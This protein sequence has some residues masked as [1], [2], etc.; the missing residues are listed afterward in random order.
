MEAMIGLGAASLLIRLGQALY[1]TG[2]IRAKNAAGS[3]LRTLADL[4]F[5]TLAFWAVGAAIFTQTRNPWFS[6]DLS[7]IAFKGTADLFFLL[8]V[9]LVGTG[10]FGGAVAERS[11]FFP[12]CAASILLAGLVI[13]I[14]ANW[15]WH[16]W[17]HRLGFTDVG[18]GAW[19]HL[20]GAVCAA[21]G[22]MLVG[23]RTGKYHRDGS[24][25][26]IPGH[27]VP[28]TGLG[29]LT[30]LVGWAPYL[31]GCAAFNG[32][33]TLMGAAATDTL[34]SAA[35]AGA[36]AILFG[37]YR[38]GKPDVILTLMGFLGGLVAISAGAGRIPAGWAFVVGAFAGL[39]VPMCAV[40]ID[41]FARLDDPIGAIA[42]HGVGGIWGTIAAGLLTYD[43]DR[44]RIE[45]VGI[46]IVGMLAIGLL[47]LVVSVALFAVLRAAGPIRVNEDHEFEGLDLAEHDIG[48]YPDFQ[49]TMIKS[50]HL[51][52]V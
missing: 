31:A 20:S 52:E 41:L 46:Q 30:M 47:S 48:A 23:P 28:M 14:G 26:M 16:G 11:R 29:A 4:C 36:A 42:I 8:A 38:Y 5:A 39:L 34:V 1:G 45:H 44:S 50:Y 15:A 19:L 33:I 12:T 9:V 37:R 2:L 6:I 32:S 21:A 3:V 24:A 22:A 27:N 49:Q 51:R 7:N 17:L 40:W 25:S 43:P 18:G 35:S 13:P 10:I